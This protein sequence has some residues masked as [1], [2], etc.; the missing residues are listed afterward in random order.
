MFGRHCTRVD[1]SVGHGPDPVTLRAVGCLQPLP[2]G[3]RRPLGRRWLWALQP[4]QLVLTA[5][6][7]RSKSTG[8]SWRRRTATWPCTRQGGHQ[9]PRQRLPRWGS[10]NCF[11]RQL[12]AP[13]RVLWAGR[14]LSAL[15]RAVRDACAFPLQT[16][17]EPHPHP[18]PQHRLHP[19]SPCVSLVLAAGWRAG[20]PRCA[21]CAETSGIV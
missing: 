15:V 10:R 11:S 21:G 12:D 5:P 20:G 19:A 9:H 2:P 1:P 3:R 7:P 16:R 17:M 13:A 6:L 18:S 14:R 8:G 4:G